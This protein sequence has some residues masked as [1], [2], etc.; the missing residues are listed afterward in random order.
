MVHATEESVTLVSE[1]D[2]LSNP[3]HLS[4]LNGKFQARKRVW[5]LI[6]VNAWGWLVHFFANERKVCNKRREVKER[7]RTRAQVID[8]EAFTLFPVAMGDY[9]NKTRTSG[10]DT[11]PAS[12]KTYRMTSWFSRWKR[13]R[14]HSKFT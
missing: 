2:L 8:G 3:S 7:A 5:V 13:E 6:G 4:H 1:G 12:F 11:E 14:K 9:F 10:T